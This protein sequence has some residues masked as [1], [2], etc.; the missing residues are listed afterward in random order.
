MYDLRA[1]ENFTAKQFIQDLMYSLCIIQMNGG[2][3]CFV[4][5]SFQE[6]FVLNLFQRLVLT[7][8][9]REDCILKA[10]HTLW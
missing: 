3:Y 8:Y 2:L 5:D 4:H 6:Y 10:I 7:V 9:V 1:E